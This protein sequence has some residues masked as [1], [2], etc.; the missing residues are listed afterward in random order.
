MHPRFPSLLPFLLSR[1]RVVS[2]VLCRINSGGTG[3]HPTDNIAPRFQLGRLL[4]YQPGPWE[5]NWFNLDG[6][7]FSLLHPLAPRVF[8]AVIATNSDFKTPNGIFY[9]L[10]FFSPHLEVESGTEMGLHSVG[11]FDSI[12]IDAAGRLEIAPDLSGVAQTKSLQVAD[13]GV[14]DLANNDLVINYTGST[15]QGAISD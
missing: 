7:V 1:R 14:F 9:L 12:S 13:G 5:P 15:P 4:S 11:D 10:G 3:I 8:E 2:Y 6:L